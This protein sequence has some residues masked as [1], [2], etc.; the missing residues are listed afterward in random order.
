MR[1]VWSGSAITQDHPRLVTPARILI[2]E[3]DRIV[4]RDLAQQLT[5]MGHVVVGTTSRGEDALSRTLDT[6]ADLVLMDIRLEGAVDGITA[7]QQI[8]DRCRIP[9]IFLTAYAD[10]ETTRRAGEAEPLGYLLKP[11]QEPQLLATIEMALYKNAADRR[12]RASEQ[13]YETTLS[14]IGDGVISTDAAATVTFMNPIAERLTGWPQAEAIGRPLA[15]VF[16]IFDGRTGARLE[17]PAARALRD[18]AVVDLPPHTILRA[19]DGRDIPIDDSSAPILAEDGQVT[20]TV[21]VFADMTGQREA[22]VA[23]RRAE[24]ELARASRLTLLGEFAASIAHEVNQPLMAIVTNAESCLRW[25]GQDQPDIRRANDAAQRVV[26]NGHRAAEVIASLR[27]LASNTSPR[28]QPLDLPAAIEDALVLLRAELERRAILLQTRFPEVLPLVTGDRVQLQQVI[29]NLV[30]NA[31][32]AIGD[33]AAGAEARTILIEVGLIELGSEAAGEV[34]VAV[35]DSG[36]G[37][38]PGI[39]VR[40]FEPLVTTKPDGMG[41]GLSISRNIVEAH[42]GRIW[43]VARQPRGTIIRFTLPLDGNA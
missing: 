5:R 3:D 32:E 8:R 40:M 33:A 29:A 35:A 26:R 17:T 34:V 39:A 43:S 38:D 25:L 30:M 37:V 7:A 1:P 14:S 4:A 11:F 15:E 9:V 41:L 36:A 10:D 31:I 18:G 22:E 28:M 12:L 21:L 13:R 20:G 42:R 16:Q 27:A 23:L 6:R 24:A 19:R 2:V